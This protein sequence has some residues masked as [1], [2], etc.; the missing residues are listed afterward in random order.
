MLSLHSPVSPFEDRLVPSWILSA[1]PRVSFRQVD[2]IPID[3]CTNRHLISSGPTGKF[4]THRRSITQYTSYSHT[5]AGGG[6]GGGAARPGPGFVAAA[7]R[8][9]FRDIHDLRGPRSWDN[10]VGPVWRDSHGRQPSAQWAPPHHSAFR[11]ER[12]LKMR[13]VICCPVPTHS[14]RQGETTSRRVRAVGTATD[15]TTGGAG[16]SPTERNLRVYATITRHQ[17]S[18]LAQ[19]RMAHSWLATLARRQDNLRTGN[20]GLT[21]STA[22]HTGARFEL[23]PPPISDSRILVEAR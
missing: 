14:E 10:T 9:T 2:S 23:P 11:G 22:R 4:V 12:S 7:C 13:F 20:V 18:L 19:L 16:G 15:D 5:A 17:T 3:R 8:L 6:V 1:T 21:H